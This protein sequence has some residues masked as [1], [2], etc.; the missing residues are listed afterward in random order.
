MDTA[1]QFKPKTI[2]LWRKAAN[3]SES[4]RI[5]NLFPGTPVKIIE[6]QS[7]NPLQRLSPGRVLIEGKRFLLI[8]HASSFVGCYDGQPGRFPDNNFTGKSVSC[9]VHC[10]PYY[11]LVPLSNGCPY[12]CTYCYLAYVYRKFSPFIKINTNYETMFKQIRK[13]LKLSDSNVC[14]NMG[15]MLDSLALDHITNL[16]KWLIP[17]FADLP[18]AY[19]MLLT[20]SC[21]INNLISTEPNNQT[22][23]SWSLNTQ[24]MIDSF[25]PGTASLNERI[26][27]AR[28]CQGHGY[29]IRFRID[30]GIIYPGWQDDYAQLI[31]NM[32]TTTNPENITLGLLRILPGH[33]NLIKQAYGKRGQMLCSYSLVKGASD[34]KMRFEPQKRIQFYSLLVDIIRSFDKKV[35]IGLCR[36]TPD[37]WNFL[38]EHCKPNQ[39]NCVVW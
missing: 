24:K 27:S 33:L 36:E 25:E 23:V 6:R 9:A 4:Q 3:D 12:Y 21:N 26:S 22:V 10:L 2:L 31:K 19:L 11:K 29:R 1:R 7:F 13:A 14:F 5:V 39:C 28:L 8:G 15:E 16:T 37:I 20:K 30:P 17:F 18:R 32:L 38:K 34:G 35:S